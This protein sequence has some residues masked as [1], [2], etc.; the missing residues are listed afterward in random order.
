MAK[1]V[2]AK[3]KLQAPGGKA[4]PAPPIGPAL[5]QHGVNIIEHFA[6]VRLWAGSFK[7]RCHL[8]GAIMLGIDRGHDAYL[9][10]NMSETRK[11]VVVGHPS[12]AN[13]RESHN[14]T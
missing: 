9:V 4:T 7:H 1:Q 14:G 13:Y 2:T 3:I 8:V 5:G 6:V 12:T 11:I 10:G